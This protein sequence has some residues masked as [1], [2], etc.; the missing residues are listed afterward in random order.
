MHVLAPSVNRSALGNRSATPADRG[1]AVSSRLPWRLGWA[2]PPLPF[3]AFAVCVF[4]AGMTYGTTRFGAS[5]PMAASAVVLVGGFLVYSVL[6]SKL[7]SLQR[8]MPFFL[9][10]VPA[11]ALNL[12]VS[13]DYLQSLPKWGAWLAALLVTY[14]LARATPSWNFERVLSAAPFL[15]MIGAA[16]LVVFGAAVAEEELGG[17][18][19]MAAT[20]FSC[21]FALGIYTKRT[22]WKVLWIGI[23]LVGI[24]VSGTRG[25][26]LTLPVALLVYT[27]YL[28]FS[29]RVKDAFGVG[30]LVVVAC[31]FV[32]NENLREAF[33]G[34]KQKMYASGEVSALV[35]LEQRQ[36]LAQEGLAIAKERPLGTG[37]GRTYSIM[38]DG[39]QLGA[40]NGY[41]DTLVQLGYPTT[42]ALFAGFAWLCWRFVKNPA[43]SRRAK[44][45]F[46]TIV[47][48]L[49]ARAGSESYSIFATANFHI[50]FVWYLAFYGAFVA[51]ARQARPARV[52]A[53]RQPVAGRP[54][55]P[56]AWQGPARGSLLVR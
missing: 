24:Y 37:A 28:F 44:A 7:A 17:R 18:L 20:Y 32:L 43:L 56:P 36:F 16:S 2:D 26:I 29:R 1:I 41:V 15:F 50:F 14:D 54:D 52:L 42:I 35:A 22:A 45:A 8:F 6:H 47:A 3:L 33:F 39:R 49:A 23:S 34:K 31:V 5:G 53:G 40:H 12:A 10:A 51:G 48:V 21:A 9:V 19:H 11:L 13:E 46:L 30:L 55:R 25:A 27:G 4:A 38:I